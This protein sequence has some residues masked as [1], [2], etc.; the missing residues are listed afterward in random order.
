MFGLP[1]EDDGSRDD[2]LLGQDPD[3]EPEYLPDFKALRAASTR[4]IIAAGAESEGELTHRAAAAVASDWAR[5][6]SSSQAATPGSSVVSTVRWGNPR[7]SPPS[8]ARSSSLP[9]NLTSTRRI[10]LVVAAVVV[11]D[12]SGAC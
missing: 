12:E 9:V 11:S 10:D 1:T 2:P 5:S 6:P 8:S 7:R 4:V 3:S